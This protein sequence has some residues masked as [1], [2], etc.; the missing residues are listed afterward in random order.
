[1][2]EINGIYTG[3]NLYVQN[4]F[5]NSGET[6][7]VYEVKVNGM[8][9]SDPFESSAFEIDLSKYSFKLGDAVTVHIY[10]RDGCLPKILN[11]EV[12]QPRTH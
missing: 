9:A 11:P 7:C 12:L 5:S 3:K 2:I 10:H 8:T 4:P 1:M 6:Y